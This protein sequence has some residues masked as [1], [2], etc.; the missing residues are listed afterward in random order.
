[1]TVMDKAEKIR[2]EIAELK[3][4]TKILEAKPAKKVTKKA[5]TKPGKKVTKKATPISNKYMLLL[6]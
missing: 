5:E 6:I 2:L 1:M 4:K 3:K